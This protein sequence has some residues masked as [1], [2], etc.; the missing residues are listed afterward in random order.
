VPVKL[1]DILENENFE[2]RDSN[3]LIAL[4]KDVSGGAVMGD[5]SKMPHLMIAGATGTGKSVCINSLIVTLLYQNSPEDLQMIMVDPKRVELSLYNGIPH[6]KGKEVIVDNNKV[7]NSLK[8]AVT[9]M[10]RRY[11]ILQEI[12]TRDIASYKSLV[13]VGKRRKVKDP[14]TGETKE[15]DLEKLPY[16]VII[17]DELSDLMLSHGK[18]IEGA[19][20]RIAQMA[21]AVGIHLIISTQRP[22]V[23][24]ITGLIK[25]N[26]GTRIAFQVATQVDSR[27]ILDMAGAEKLLGK[28]DMLYVSAASPKPKRIQGAFITENEV[29]KVVSFIKKQNFKEQEEE[30]IATVSEKN[31]SGPANF[32]NFKQEEE[33][34]SLYEAAK[35]EVIRSKK[36]STTFLQRR[37]RVGY[38]RAARIMDLLEEKGIIGPGD[39]AKIREIYA[40][41]GEGE[42]KYEDGSKDQETRDKWQM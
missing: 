24:V 25:A 42:T 12:G 4:G 37:L 7:I 5:I 39:G 21:R 3:L 30:Q 19:V 17:I 20:V 40:S 6:L 33:T 9:E 16:V 22:S 41:S 34:D 35:E 32:E 26:I 36:A 8:W 2:N 13:R 18:E 29:K 31:E 23:E 10:E 1:R 11:K 38:A 28:G 15:F 27:T 14:E